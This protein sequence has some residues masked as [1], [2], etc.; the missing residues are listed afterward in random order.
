MVKK[1]SESDSSSSSSS[2]SSESVD[3]VVVKTAKSKAKGSDSDSNSSAQPVS[4]KR[5]ARSNSQSTDSNTDAQSSSASPSPVKG[6]ARLHSDASASSGKP[7]NIGTDGESVSAQSADNNS[8]SEAPATQ[9]SGRPR[10]EKPR[11]Y[12]RLHELHHKQLED[13]KHLRD[14]SRSAMEYQEVHNYSAKRIQEK[15]DKGEATIHATEKQALFEKLF[16]DSKKRQQTKIDIEQAAEVSLQNA[17][18][19][20][21]Q[22][23]K[24]RSARASEKLAKYRALR[25]Q[26]GEVDVNDEDSEPGQHHLKL[27]EHHKQKLAHRQKEMDEREEHARQE[28]EK[29]SVH[30]SLRRGNA[31]PMDVAHD[32]S[33]R[34]HADAQNR[35]EKIERYRRAETRKLHEQMH[36]ESVHRH[37]PISASQAEETTRRLAHEDVQRRDQRHRDRQAHTHRHAKSNFDRRHRSKP[38]TISLQSEAAWV[39]LYADAKRREVAKFQA[40][41]LALQLE[42]QEMHKNSVHTDALALKH[43]EAVRK[44]REKVDGG[45]DSD[46]GP[47]GAR[48]SRNRKSSSKVGRPKSADARES[49]D[50]LRKR[51]GNVAQTGQDMDRSE[52]T[53]KAKKLADKKNKSGGLPRQSVLLGMLADQQS[54]QQQVLKLVNKAQGDGPGQRTHIVVTDTPLRQKWMSGLRE[55]APP[56]LTPYAALQ[57]MQPREPPP[58]QKQRQNQDAYYLKREQA[59][60]LDSGDEDEKV[61]IKPSLAVASGLRSSPP[62]K[63]VLSPKAAFPTTIG[64]SRSWTKL[65]CKPDKEG[66][67][68]F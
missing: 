60:P 37:C 47:G 26:A 2:S 20:I 23:H 54:H 9:V 15:H 34:L 58:P 40:E 16:A 59:K 45:Y 31:S 56:A 52:G 62:S 61:P 27:F 13:R 5:R 8:G 44:A 28:L 57:L 63:G 25:R 38:G 48:R 4:P 39:G 30:R 42:F 11:V 53:S 43:L 55:N 3:K 49:H 7:D 14:R 24:E 29:N 21:E 12:D 64:T 22:S 6:R 46:P 41:M 10:E 50:L 17:A 66:L 19:Q 32:V 33:S 35:D 18:Q 67:F 68:M 1:K 65:L 36:S 51:T